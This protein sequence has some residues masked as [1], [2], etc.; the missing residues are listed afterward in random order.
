M[1]FGGVL[2]IKILLCGMVQKTPHDLDSSHI[3]FKLGVRSK[4][5][6][7]KTNVE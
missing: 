6:K 7:V 4:I 1:R 5:K 2:G 3:N